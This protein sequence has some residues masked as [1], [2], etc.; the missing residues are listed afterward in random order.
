MIHRLF[1]A[2][3]AYG[4]SGYRRKE[5]IDERLYDLLSEVYGRS[6]GL[7]VVNE[8]ARKVFTFKSAQLGYGDDSGDIHE[9][10]H[11]L[12]THSLVTNWK[13]VM[14]DLPETLIVYEGHGE[15]EERLTMQI[16]RSKVRKLQD[17]FLKAVVKHGKDS[18]KNVKGKWFLS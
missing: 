11:E 5:D 17:D 7:D 14:R 15:D 8:V 3:T 2:A 16:S 18:M 10:V 1:H 9:L 13:P 12:L 6:G 4:T